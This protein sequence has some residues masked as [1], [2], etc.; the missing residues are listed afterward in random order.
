MP[1]Q[2][3]LA[4]ILAADV[5]GYSRLTSADEE[6]TL[7]RM[8][9]LRSDLI[10]PTVEAHNG[11]VV[12]RTGDGALVEFRSVVEAVRCAIR[13]QDAMTERNA[14]LPPDRHIEFRMGVHLGD[15][16]EESDGDLMGDGVNIAAR[17]EGV[18]EPGAICLSEDAYR[19]VKA[20]LN[21]MVSDLGDTK[22][23]NIAEP[24]RIYSLKAGTAE[25][26]KQAAT[27]AL[28]TASNLPDKPS[29]AVLPFT[30]MSG[31]LEQEYF[32]DGMV[33]DIITALSRFNQLFVIARNSSFVYKG[34]AVD[35]KQVGREL[36]VRY[37]L[38]GSVRKAGSRVRITGQLIDAATGAHLWA[39][40]FDGEL[41][42]V[43][44]LQDRI[45]ASVVGAIEPTM[46]KAEIERSRRKPADN[47][48]AYDLYL[49]ALPHVY[50]IRE[51]DNRKALD[52][53]NKAIDL[54]PSYG[55]A[56][57]H[58]AWCLVQRITRAWPPINHDDLATAI[59]LAR[60]ALAA[61]DDDAVS[62]VLGGFALVMVG[63]D[64]ATGLDAVRR[65]VDLNPGSGFV[66]A[67]AGCA[68]IFGD[69]LDV[70]LRHLERAMALGPLDPNF[71]SHLTV[72][73][74][75]RLFGGRPDLAAELAERSLALNAEWD[76]TYW[77]LISAYTQLDR[78]PEARTAAARLMAL[79]PEATIDKYRKYLPIRNPDSL[80]IVLKGLR[81][82]GLPEGA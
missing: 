22:L 38:E 69:N 46:R 28:D 15:V 14:G 54:D 58:A 24:V 8:R 45:T 12:K 52:L 74:C 71:F 37:V 48:G 39:D 61:G 65:A 16:V 81:Q 53:L 75:A 63:R 35:V 73:A 26:T 31:D 82:A 1:E 9:A 42:D 7:A 17:L 3:K 13:V 77:V 23:K 40:R 66:N 64:Y 78:L 32:V 62:I 36:G 2:R 11:R 30:N 20:R 56:L 27:A 41:E 25:P 6:G 60:R 67:V 18:A 72:A 47:L 70:G 10:D 50:T 33:E 55:P 5:V 76:S 59:S 21:L 80:E 19:Q 51:V 44:D 29:I 4:A 34:S 49:Q 68:Q 79:S 43:F 57:A